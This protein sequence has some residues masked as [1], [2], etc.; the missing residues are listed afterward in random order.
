MS[1]RRPLASGNAQLVVYR[2]PTSVVNRVQ[3]HSVAFSKA[4]PHMERDS[5]PESLEQADIATAIAE[6]GDH[7]IV[8]RERREPVVPLDHFRKLVRPP[9]SLPSKSPNTA[10]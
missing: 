4:L 9:L 3:R 10:R 2:F 6:A 8:Q 7:F 1:S 5:R